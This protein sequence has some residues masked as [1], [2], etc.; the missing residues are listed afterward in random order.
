[1]FI[2]FSETSLFY[3]NC[4]QY[5]QTNISNITTV[6]QCDRFWYR[7]G[8]NLFK[9]RWICAIETWAYRT[10]VQR[11]LLIFTI[12]PSDTS[13]L[14]E[15]G[16]L[17]ICIDECHRENKIQVGTLLGYVPEFTGHL[18]HRLLLS[19]RAIENW[20]EKHTHTNQCISEP[21]FVSIVSGG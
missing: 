21:Y 11:E 6:W 12:Q 19:L 8:V 18:W 5:I 3:C 9:Q 17:W 20:K 14:S 10:P 7:C 2:R 15:N 13:H 4:F 1:M 16:Q